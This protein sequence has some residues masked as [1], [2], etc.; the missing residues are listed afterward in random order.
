[1]GADGVGVIKMELLGRWSSKGSWWGGGHQKGASR[2]VVIKR[3]LI[4]R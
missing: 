2:E 4:G 1:M 3:V